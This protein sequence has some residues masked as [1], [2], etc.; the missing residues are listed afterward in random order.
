MLKE[1][2]EAV[3]HVALLCGAVVG[4]FLVA[5]AVLQ[6]LFPEP[7]AD[8]AKLSLSELLRRAAA[9]AAASGALQPLATRSFVA[10]QRGIPFLVSVLEPR[11]AKAKPARSP[12]DAFAALPPSA[13]VTRLPRGPAPTHAVVLK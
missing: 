3:V 4:G 13:L 9:R 1:R 7:D 6:R 11:A 10:E 5:R 2:K 8:D 12:V